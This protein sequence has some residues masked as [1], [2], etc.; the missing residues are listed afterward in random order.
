MMSSL[1]PRVNAGLAVS[2][3]KHWFTVAKKGVELKR[4]NNLI[5]LPANERLHDAMSEWIYRTLPPEEA[6]RRKRRA[7]SG[8]NLAPHIYITSEKPHYSGPQARKVSLLKS[9]M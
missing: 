9:M 2:A 5:E 7:R 1:T 6:Y 4:A 3:V 8:Q